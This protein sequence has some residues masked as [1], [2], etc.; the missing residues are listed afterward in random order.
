MKILIKRQ[1]QDALACDDA[2]DA[3]EVL[4]EALEQASE[5][6]EHQEAQART[7]DT[8]LAE[9]IDVLLQYPEGQDLVHKWGEE[10]GFEKKT[11]II[12]GD[13][14]GFIDDPDDP[15]DLDHIL[16][17]VEMDLSNEHCC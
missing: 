1:I 10:L 9:A 3:V 11:T 13:P 8:R 4:R 7:M 12:H 17:E 6:I 16:E 2:A 14:R 5:L 15:D